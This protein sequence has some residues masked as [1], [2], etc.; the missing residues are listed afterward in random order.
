MTV[1]RQRCSSPR[2]MT[3]TNRKRTPRLVSARTLP[4]PT[5]Y[6]DAL[7]GEYKEWAFD[8]E[9][10]KAHCGNWRTQFEVSAQHPLDLEIGTGN[11]YFFAHRAESKPERAL[12]GV[13]L[14][15][16]PLIQSI[17]RAR[18]AGC[19][20]A[21]IARYDAAC[22]EDIIGPGEVN[23][24]FIYHPDPW[25]RLRDHKHRLIQE[26]FLHTLFQLMRPGSSLRFKT[27]DESYFDWAQERFLRSP[28]QG[29]GSTRDLHRSQWAEE[30]FITH[31]ERLFLQ[32]GQPIFWS[33]W[34]RP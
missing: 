7:Y 10:A 5:V 23:D 33:Q 20:N 21:R 22:I 32:K 17:R 28:F 1:R 12:L 15:F 4:N 9:D 26:V 2:T 30:N 6:V 27:D 13:E 18:K 29:Q 8:E 11:G 34:L 24:V 14:K 25:P 31:F 3:E 16:K 19:T